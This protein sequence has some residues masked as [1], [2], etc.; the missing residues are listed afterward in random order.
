MAYIYIGETERDEIGALTVQYRNLG[1]HLTQTPAAVLWCL[2]QTPGRFVSRDT[3]RQV[4]TDV[5]GIES[6][7]DPIGRNIRRIREATE[8]L[9]DA[10]IIENVA[11]QGYRVLLPEGEGGG[12]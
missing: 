8:G 3:L 4:I 7:R 11:R 10:P 6:E 1:R 9:P 2:M 5:N 12:S